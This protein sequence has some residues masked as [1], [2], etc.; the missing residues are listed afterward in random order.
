MSPK[1]AVEPVAKAVFFLEDDENA[2][3]YQ[4]MVIEHS[5]SL[6]LVATWI[7]GNRTGVRYPERIIPM[8]NLPHV[9][10][11]DGS[12]RLGPILPREL[13]SAEASRSL[14]QKY[15]AVIHPGLSQI[16][17]HGSIQ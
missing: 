16:P 17:A 6:W 1:Y 13:L 8:E 4:A 5:N 12:I 9:V 14:L 3:E 7:E 15:G 10:Q 2:F 11:K